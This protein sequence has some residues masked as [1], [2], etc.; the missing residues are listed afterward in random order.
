MIKRGKHVCPVARCSVLVPNRLLMCPRHW[1]L[2]PHRLKREVW[3]H[4]VPGQEDTG[5]QTEAYNAAACAARDAAQ[6]A[7][8][9]KR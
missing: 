8:E 9:S 3:K 4:Y 5:Y 7:E 1:S 6:A 2:V